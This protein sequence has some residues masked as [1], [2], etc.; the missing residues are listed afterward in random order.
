MLCLGTACASPGLREAEV[1][2][3]VGAEGASGHMML[4]THK[5]GQQVTGTHYSGTWY[6]TLT[7]RVS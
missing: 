6:P 1:E 5:A 7:I 2:D 4:V 3:L